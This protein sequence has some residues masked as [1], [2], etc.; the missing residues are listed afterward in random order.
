MGMLH[1]EGLLQGP[2]MRS[3]TPLPTTVLV[4]L[5]PMTADTTRRMRRATVDALLA[6]GGA[7]GMDRVGGGAGRNRQVGRCAS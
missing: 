4:A 3:L 7:R 5:D 1:V 6:F 2:L